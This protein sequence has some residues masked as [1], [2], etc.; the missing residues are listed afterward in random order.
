MKSKRSKEDTGPCLTIKVRSLVIDSKD[1]NS[2]TPTENCL[3]L[4]RGY[5]SDGFVDSLLVG[6]G[7]H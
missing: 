5:S 1:S 4:P 2:D 3:I 7:A 6:K